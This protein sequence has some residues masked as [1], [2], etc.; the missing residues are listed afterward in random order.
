M[1]S[2][3]QK[4]FKDFFI[5]KVQTITSS[6]STENSLPET[7]PPL[8]LN[9]TLAEF[10]PVTIEEVISI[11]ISSNKTIYAV[12]QFDVRLLNN[13]SLHTSFAACATKFLNKSLESGTFPQSE[14]LA[15]IRSL[16]KNGKDSQDFPH[17]GF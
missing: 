16:L 5:S 2:F 15:C 17:T 1:I 3:L 12:E 7:L 9:E 8:T 14:K 13:E 10:E 6:F 11:I 4:K